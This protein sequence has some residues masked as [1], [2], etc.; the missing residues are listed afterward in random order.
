MGCVGGGYVGAAVA[1]EDG[2]A[3]VERE[4]AGSAE[5]HSG[6]G[7]AVF[8]VTAVLA[9]AFGVVGAVVDGVQGD[10]LARQLGAHELH[11]VIEV[12]LG[13]EAAGYAGLVGDDDQ[14][15]AEG[16]G[17]EAERD[18]ALDPANIGGEIEIAGFVVDYAVAVQKEGSGFDGKIHGWDGRAGTQRNKG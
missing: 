7:F 4:V 18:D 16:L 8:V 1:Y 3:E 13:V 15:V 6:A 12:P 9:E 5:E 10:A 14:L 17:G 2:L 11:E